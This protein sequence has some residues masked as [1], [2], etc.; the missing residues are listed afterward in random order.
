MTVL[1]IILV[2]IVLVILFTLQLISKHAASDK[3]LVFYKDKRTQAKLVS[4]TD[5]KIEFSIDVPYEN[6]SGDEG[7]FLDA[8]VRIYLPDEQYNGALLRGRVNHPQ[9]PR[10]DDYFEARLV[11]PGEKDHLTVTVEVTPRNG[12]KTAEAALQDMPDVEF[13]LYV[14]RRGRMELFHNKENILLTKE[15]LQKL[16]K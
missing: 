11:P 12:K 8:F 13:A 16:L 3:L 10:E 5:D 9:A 14:E 7:I 6:K 15:E 1:G 2:L 4:K